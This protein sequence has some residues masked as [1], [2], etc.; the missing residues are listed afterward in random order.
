MNE[1][2]AVFGF[3]VIMII[4]IVWFKSRERL[5][6]FQLQADLYLAALEKGHPPLTNW[7]NWFI[8]PEKPEKKS[9]ALKWGLICMAI[10]IGFAIACWVVAVTAGQNASAF[11]FDDDIQVMAVV[12]KMLSSIGVIPFLIGIAFV[13]VHFI[14]KKKEEIKEKVK[15][16]Q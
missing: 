9:I 11:P 1:V 16:A 7:A 15:N 10:G 2:V 3:P 6:R 14:D 4:L 12:F 5:K 13:I 8:E